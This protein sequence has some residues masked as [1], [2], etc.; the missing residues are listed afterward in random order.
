MKRGVVLINTGRGALIDTQKA[1]RHLRDATRHALP[2]LCARIESGEAL[3]EESWN[4]LLAV[5]RQALAVG[6]GMSA[7][8]AVEPVIADIALRAGWSSRR[9][10]RRPL[11]PLSIR[12]W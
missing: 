9:T 2:E 11:S 5:A 6:A 12:P 1:E 7:R 8:G 4:E 3:A 10:R